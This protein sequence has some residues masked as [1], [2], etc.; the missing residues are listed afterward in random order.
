MAGK[1]V[2]APPYRSGNELLAELRLGDVLTFLA[3]QRYG[4]LTGAA[5][6]LV[7]TPSMV[8]KAVVRLERQLKLKLLHRGVRGVTLTEPALRV[9][10]HL[11]RA[12]GSFECAVKLESEPRRVLSV[13]GPSYLVWLGLPAIAEVL[14]RVPLR[15]IELPPALLRAHAAQNFFDLGLLPGR[16][17]LPP[18]WQITRVGEIRKSLLAR[19]ALARR[20]GPPPVPVERIR[21]VPFVNP[22]YNV[23]GLFV[24]VDDDCPLTTAERR[25]GHE[26]Q[27]I[28]VALELASCTDELVHGPV[29]AARRHIIDGRLVEIEVEGWHASEPLHV[30]GNTQ[31]LLAPELRAIIAALERRFAE[32]AHPP[33]AHRR[34]QARAAV[35]RRVGR[36]D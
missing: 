19:P 31:R 24:P 7:V 16:A 26:A 27:T 9:M 13:A 15:G 5:R 10:P 30:V 32:P 21:E 33:A 8:S 28:A 25:P 6:E 4:S 18:T 35:A 1:T 17:R 20:L 22:V 14:P 2:A 29:I 11:E 12:I 3:V 23:G 34:A 36:G